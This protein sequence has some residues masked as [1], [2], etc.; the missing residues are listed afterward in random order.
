MHGFAVL[1]FV[2]WQLLGSRCYAR[3][4]SFALLEDDST[5]RKRGDS[6]CGSTFKPVILERSEESRNC[7]CGLL[8][9]ISEAV[10]AM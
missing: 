3:A 4:R 5:G 2:L 10:T 6:G 9:V 7:K 8:L 1:F